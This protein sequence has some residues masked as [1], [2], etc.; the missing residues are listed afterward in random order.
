MSSI[1]SKSLQIYNAKQFLKSISGE[2]GANVYFSFGTVMPW[3]NESLPQ[4]ANTSV[5]GMNDVW[6]NMIGAKR[7]IGNDVHHVV[8]RFDWTSG[9]IYYGYDDLTD[10]SEMMD[11]NTRFY[12][13]TDDWNVYKC[14]SNNYG[15]PS[16]SKPTSTLSVP[17]MTDDEYIWKYMTTLTAEERLKFS[18]RDYIP[19]KTLSYNDGSL[20][21]DVQQNA[22]AG[23]IHAVKVTNHGTGYSSSNL[24]V[25]ITGDG[26]G[27]NAYATRNTSANSVQTIIIDDAGEGYTYAYVNVISA[28]GSGATARAI[29]SPP[30]GH[31]SDPITELGASNLMITTKFIGYQDG[32]FIV[33]NDFRQIA[34]IAN[35][36]RHGT[37]VVAD[38][39]AVNQVTTITLNGVSADYEYDEYVYQ[40]ASLATA[41]FS[42]VVADWDS[43]NNIIKISNVEGIPSSALLTGNTSRA[44][45]FLDTTKIFNPD[46][47]PYTG[48]IL[49]INNIEPISRSLDQTESF[50]VI[51]RF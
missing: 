30:G 48:Q 25:T 24:Y 14:L 6:N 50:Q 33:N 26:T 5:R 4:Q 18:T 12:V 47:E 42:G 40:G 45:R 34:I 10:S 16:T 3:A 43:P 51:L 49:Y 17:Q 35:P 37:T 27:A 41:T 20:Q 11:G 23:G 2:L 31:G 28:N 46:L 39:T 8:S 36:Y 9:D 29:I 13:V 15:K 1:H 7:V 22:I 38:N 32:K 21:W 19:V 44:S